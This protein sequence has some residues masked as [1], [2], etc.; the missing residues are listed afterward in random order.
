MNPE[1]RATLAGLYQRCDAWQGADA[2][3]RRSPAQLWFRHRARSRLAVL[4]YHG[5]EDRS[6]FEAHL[7][8]LCDRSAPVSLRQV[9]EAARGGPP[10]PPRAVL[11]T[12]DDG[13][14][15]VHRDALPALKA[16]GI[17]AVCF[18]VAGLVGTDT[19]FWWDEVEQLA[20]AGGTTDLVPPAAPELLP[21]TLKLLPERRRR[22]ALR[23]LRDS[24]RTPVAR[25]PQLTEVQLRELAAGGV[26]IGNHTLTHPCLDRCDDRQVR[27]EVLDAHRL[28][29]DCLGRPPTAFAY[30]NGNTDARVHRLLGEA[31]YRSGFLYNHRLAHPGARH[32]LRIDRLVVSTRA[33]ADRLETIL[34]GLH[35]TV[36]ALAR[37]AARAAVR[38]AQAI[39]R[40]S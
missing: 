24:A 10:L 31:G 33:S 5:I 15:S 26:D 30:P 11:V 4:G 14:V 39:R 34:S 13:D 38:S 16:R 17:P 12:F 3:L 23:Q 1:L 9:E 6:S 40:T 8:R 19:P 37:G 35:S 7:D 21:H 25:K 20:R 18:V 32:P 29:T 2:L 22:E 27:A 28:L 36:F